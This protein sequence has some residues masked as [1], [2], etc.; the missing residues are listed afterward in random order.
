MLRLEKKLL[1]ARKIKYIIKF[2]KDR[3]EEIKMINNLKKLSKT[4][5]QL[6]TSYGSKND[7]VE[8]K[9]IYL[10]IKDF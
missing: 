2:N 5:F 6:L 7:G 9:S 8:A 3:S 1:K 4:Y 10:G